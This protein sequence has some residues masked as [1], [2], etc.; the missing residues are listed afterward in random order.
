MRTQRSR[1][2]RIGVRSGRD[3]LPA[4]FMHARHQVKA[5]DLELEGRLYDYETQSA[6]RRTFKT[7]GITMDVFILSDG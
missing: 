2:F 4:G 5:A 7:F 3:V 1:L 6:V